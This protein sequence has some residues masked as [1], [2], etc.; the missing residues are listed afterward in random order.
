MG[1]HHAVRRPTGTATACPT[2]SSTRSGARSSGTATSAPAPRPKLAA[3]RPIEV[4][5]P[6]ARSRSRWTWGWL[7]PKGKAL[8]DPVADHA[9]RPSTGTATACVDL[10]MLDHE[11]YLA[12]FERARRDGK[13]GAAA[14]PAGVRRRGGPAAA[15]ERR[16]GGQERPAQALRRP[17]GTATASSTS[18][19]TP[20]TPGSC[21]RSARRDGQWLFATPGSCRPGTSRGTTSARR[22]STSTATASPTVL[23]AEDG[24]LYYLRNPRTR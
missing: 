23:G 9:G 4:E 14:A 1:L 22:S 21:G 5:W 2:S 20:P 16:H 18:W 11:G 19:S 10:V 15:A 13:L 7:S 3:A 6:T 17:T 24:R 12:F 8:A